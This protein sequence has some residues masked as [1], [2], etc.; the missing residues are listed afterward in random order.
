MTKKEQAPDPGI[1]LGLPT[2]AS[3]MSEMFPWE[4]N[5]Q[6]WP[7]VH[8]ACEQQEW[9]QCAGGLWSSK[10]HNGAFSSNQVESL[11]GRRFMWLWREHRAPVLWNYLFD[12]LLPSEC[13]HS[14]PG[15]FLFI[16]HWH[17]CDSCACPQ[18]TGSCTLWKVSLKINNYFEMK[19]TWGCLYQSEVKQKSLSDFVHS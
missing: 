2:Q 19:S 13:M 6:K 14:W 15:P 12:P 4:W 11:L 17:C 3:N 10:E 18:G 9:S 1:R 16:N 7:A 5:L 8:F